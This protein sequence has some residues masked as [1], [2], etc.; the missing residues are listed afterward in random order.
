MTEEKRKHNWYGCYKDGEFCLHSRMGSSEIRDDAEDA[1]EGH[2]PEGQK[3][4]DD[5]YAD[6]LSY[7]SGADKD[8]EKLKRV[9][10]HN[11][12]IRFCSMCPFYGNAKECKTH[13]KTYKLKVFY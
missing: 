5:Y 8:A 6:L 1:N 13:R 12:E 7:S 9:L 10:N 3:N 4:V 2:G 11:S